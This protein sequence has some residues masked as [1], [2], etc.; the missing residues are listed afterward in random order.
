MAVAHL[1]DVK[2]GLV[3]HYN[4]LTESYNRGAHI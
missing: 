4:Q 2:V 3:L 1:P